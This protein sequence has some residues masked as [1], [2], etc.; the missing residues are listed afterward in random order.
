MAVKKED[1]IYIVLTQTGTLLSRILKQITG[2]EYNHVSIGVSKNLDEMYSFGRK[3]PYYPFWGGFVVESRHYGTFKRFKNTKAMVIEISVGEQTK[4][5][6]SEF[7]L[8]I[9][10]NR[11]A[12]HYN[13]FGLVLAYFNIFLERK[14]YFYCSEFVRFV[15]REFDVE[16]SQNME[17]IVQPIHFLEL[18]YSDVIYTGKLCDYS[19]EMLIQ[20]IELQAHNSM[21]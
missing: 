20:P 11:K 8:K 5:Q 2:A 4:K 1:K 3:N 10:E 14:N 7:V 18:P 9:C 13:Y 15:L 19:K 16:G 12:Y 21:N 6:I 17:D